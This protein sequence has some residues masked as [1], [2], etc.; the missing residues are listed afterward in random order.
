MPAR[1]VQRWHSR[2]AQTARTAHQAL[3]ASGEPKLRAVAQASASQRPR[4]LTSSS[5]VTK[6]ETLG[7]AF[8]G[9]STVFML[10]PP[11]QQAAPPAR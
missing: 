8:E 9:A 4:A 2:L 3:A 10:T 7:P 11:H 6:P 5:D 1:T